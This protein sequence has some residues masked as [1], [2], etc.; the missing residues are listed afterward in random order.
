LIRVELL[1]RSGRVHS[2]QIGK[3]D[4]H[5]DQ[6]GDAPSTS[7]RVRS[8]QIGKSEI[9]QY[10]QVCALS[11]SVRSSFIKINKG[12][13][14]PDQSERAL[15]RSTKVCSIQISKSELYQDQQGFAL[16]RL[17]TVRSIKEGG[18]RDSALSRWT[19]VR[20]IQM[21]EGES[22]TSK[23]RPNCARTPNSSTLTER[24]AMTACLSDKLRACVCGSLCSNLHHPYHQPLVPGQI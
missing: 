2:I 23:G 15:S 14:Y 1:S 18:G 17:A 9:Y 3:G 16:S 4:P 6:E 12:P 19:T 13:L 24:K 10:P 20:F 7:T 8:I 11:R 5:Q 21:E 22:C